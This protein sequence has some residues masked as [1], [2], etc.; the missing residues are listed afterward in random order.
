MSLCPHLQLCCRD[1]SI[2]LSGDDHSLSVDLPRVCAP[3]FILCAVF[4]IADR[5]WLKSQLRA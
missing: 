5:V 2:V 4:M 3:T 1:G